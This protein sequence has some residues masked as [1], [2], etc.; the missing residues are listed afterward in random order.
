ME[1]YR[2]YTD[3]EF[4]QNKFRIENFND[5]NCKKCGIHFWYKCKKTLITCSHECSQLFEAENKSKRANVCNKEKRIL[6]RREK[7]K[8]ITLCGSTGIQDQIRKYALELTKKGILVEFAPFRKEDLP[9]IEEYRDICERIHF[10][11]IEM[12]DEVHIILKNNHLGEHTKLELEYA[13]SLNKKIE[14]IGVE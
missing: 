12:A 4:I 6:L 1:S 10:K 5:G 3:E 7:L 13:R 11:K 2:R 14:F 9:E 8:I